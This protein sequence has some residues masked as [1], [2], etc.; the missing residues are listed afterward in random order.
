MGATTVLLAVVL[1]VLAQV[2]ARDMLSSTCSFSTPPPPNLK[3]ALS[4]PQR[5]VIRQSPQQYAHGPGGH[6][7]RGAE[8]ELQPLRIRS[9]VSGGDDAG[10]SARARL[11][12]SLMPAVHQ[13]IGRLLHV[14]PIAPEQNLT[15]VDPTLCA[16]YWI[17]REHIGAPNYGKCRRI[18][19]RPQGATTCVFS[20]VA[21][22]DEHLFLEYCPEVSGPCTVFGSPAG[23]AD[24]D[25]VLYVHIANAQSVQP[26]DPFAPSA[27]AS[28]ACTG[29]GASISSAGTC[30][31]DQ[32][33]RPIA[34]AIVVCPEVLGL[35][36]DTLLALLAHEALHALGFSSSMFPYFRDCTAERTPLGLCQ[37]R[38]LRRPDG[39]PLDYPTLPNTMARAAGTR[40]FLTT[41]VLVD[42]ARA[43][44]ACDDAAAIGVPLEDDGDA[45]SA[46]QHWEARVLRDD[47]M[48]PS[49]T[50]AIDV[51]HRIS[52]IT[53]AALADSG[54]YAPQFAL[55]EPMLWGQGQGC[56]F[57][58]NEACGS[59]HFCEQAGE[60][61]CTLDRTSKGSC[62]AVSS[63]M[64]GCRFMAPSPGGS[65]LAVQ[66]PR[67]AYEFEAFSS[68]S[69]CFEGLFGIDQLQR[70]VC[71]EHRCALG[72]LR[73]RTQR[74]AAWM[75]CSSPDTR[76]V[77]SNDS[78]LPQG[79]EILC[80]DPASLCA[81]TP[82]FK[83]DHTAPHA[84][85]ALIILG[86]F[87]AS[88][89]ASGEA[90]NR[91]GTAVAGVI[92]AWMRED[93]GRALV[94]VVNVGPVAGHPDL[95]KLT[96]DILHGPEGSPR[97]LTAVMAQ[98]RT[99][100]RAGEIIAR[101]LGRE[102][103]ALEAIPEDEGAANS[104]K[105]GT[106]VTIGAAVG[107]SLLLLVVLAG[108]QMHKRACPSK[109]YSFGLPT[110]KHS[111]ANKG[112]AAAVGPG[113]MRHNSTSK[114]ILESRFLVLVQ[115]NARPPSSPPP[116]LPIILENSA[117]STS[118]PRSPAR[119]LPAP[120]GADAGTTSTSS[121][122]GA[123]ASNG[124]SS[125]N[126]GSR[127]LPVPPVRPVRGSA[128]VAH[129]SSRT[130]EQAESSV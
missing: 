88:E 99:R 8:Q 116:P 25:I 47:I 104:G 123:S 114:A 52:N 57:L 117:G 29:T 72:R 45:L 65:C 13:R 58:T 82:G 3:A 83:E 34:G 37:P 96:L 89:W 32:G 11:E 112:T 46:G 10:G 85:H 93:F 78:S 69:R 30:W 18:Q 26:L 68:S 90:P 74:G 129:E 63:F 105:S 31:R 59:G 36:Q 22:P 130:A 70:G 75:T 2:C 66:A 91:V 95:I 118:S 97:N 110:S 7:R 28:L 122:D 124:N 73:V 81:S 1:L 23:I 15:L 92:N 44:F 6:A 14:T 115:E 94:D 48:G 121:K 106:A 9:F 79:L 128:G 102:F 111:R 80:A 19:E 56:S 24:A 101:V 71:L 42:A 61:G 119:R 39:A 5:P 54:W 126:T 64:S 87:T 86:R 17:Q 51:P 21:I 127:R 67:E 33:D 49:L 100:I 84:D 107:V 20:S 41:P 108:V 62:T 12:K 16:E 113:L 40:Q 55:A 27:E 120:P 60:R 103:S 43:F 76:L 50:Q 38:V 35:S 98:L 125:S 109:R 53:L 4:A 77:A